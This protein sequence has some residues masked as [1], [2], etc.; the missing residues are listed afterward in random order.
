MRSTFVGNRVRRGRLG[1]HDQFGDRPA[2]RG[3]TPRGPRA[4]PQHRSV[5][6]S[7]P[8]PML[9]HQHAGQRGR[10]HTSDTVVGPSAL[11][12]GP[13]EPAQRKTHDDRSPE[14]AAVRHRDRRPRRARARAPRPRARK[15]EGQWALGLPRA[16]EPERADQEGRRT[17]STSG[18]GSR[19]ST[20][21]AASPRSTPATCAAASA[22]SASTP[23]ARPGFDGGKTA[24]LEPHEL[25]DEFFM[26]RV[27]SDGAL[28]GA[29]QLRA[30]GEVS[31]A[32][33]R[34]TADVTDRQNIQYHWIRIEDVPAIWERLE[35]V[36][37]QHHR[38]LRRLPAP[39]P[40]L[41][42]RRRGQGRDHRRLPRAGGDQAPLHRRPRLRQPAPQVQD[43]R[44]R[45][46]E[47]GRR[48]RGQRRQLR[49][50]RPP[51]ARPRL[52][53]LGR[54][55]PVDQPDAGPE[56]RRLDPARGGRRRLGG[57]A[58]ASS[59]TTATAGC[60]AAPA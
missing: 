52:R 12:P 33:A 49:R 21:T 39:V 59:A 30:L 2:P 36:G 50:H 47:P 38:G 26:M 13:R 11:V 24:T 16:A 28:L 40:R 25:D 42:R 35:G 55:R 56:A 27:R 8:S 32:Y 53:P 48:P 3:T 22:G 10:R 14:S 44:D 31:T 34:G 54:R 60:A 17:R 37:P 15:G 57:R 45:P 18:P 29:E 58:S 43:L 7:D 6:R 19:T 20:P 4:H 5:C 41:P 1:S 9:T 51:R 46:P 23:S